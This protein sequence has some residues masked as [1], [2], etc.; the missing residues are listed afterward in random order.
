MSEREGEDRRD[1]EGDVF[2]N[3]RVRHPRR[4]QAHW[5]KVLKGVAHAVGAAVLLIAGTVWTIRMQHPKYVNPGGLL[6]LPAALVNAPTPADSIL[7]DTTAPPPTTA[8]GMAQVSRI[9]QFL[10]AYTSDA[11]RARR[12]ASAIVDQGTKRN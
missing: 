9:A 1:Q 4:E 6:Q 5:V 7:A 3:V 8:A 12:I 10:H 2:T 11:V